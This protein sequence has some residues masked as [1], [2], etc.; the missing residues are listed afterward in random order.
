MELLHITSPLLYA[1][2]VYLI[3]KIPP[4]SDDYFMKL[5]RYNYN[6]FMSVFSGIMFIMIT[7]GNYQ[8]NKMYPLYN[9]LCVSYENNWYAYTGAKLFLWSK[10]IEWLD[11]LY[12]H[13][14]NKPISYLQYTHH[15]ST[16]F[17]MYFNIKD[18]LSPHIYVFMGSNCVVHVFMY[19]YFA[20]PKGVLYPY[21]QIITMSQIAQHIICLAT[22]YKTYY[23]GNE[24]CEQNK[25]G[26][27]FGFLMYN[28][29]LLFFVAFYIKKYLYSNKFFLKQN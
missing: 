18:Y 22:I 26:N 14:S 23:I 21:R 4:C 3:Q 27:F 20:E 2:F 29:Y 25:Y 6:L 28:M 9:L 10:Y 8:T 24:L 5:G 17:L 19:W 16:A 11:T 15:M 13:L 12:L 7:I 1:G